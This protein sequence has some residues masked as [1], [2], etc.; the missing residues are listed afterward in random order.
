MKTFKLLST[1]TN[2]IGNLTNRNLF[3]NSNNNRNLSKGNITYEY[4]QDIEHIKS[5]LESI[6]FQNNV[7]SSNPA[8]KK[9]IDKLEKYLTRIIKFF[10]ELNTFNQKTFK[11]LIESKLIPILTDTINILYIN[12]ISNK[13]MPYLHKLIFIDNKI[14]AKGKLKEESTIINTQLVGC[15]KKIITEFKNILNNVNIIN[16]NSDLDIFINNGILP[17]LNDLFCKLIKYP[18][19]YYALVNDSTTIN[20]NLELLLFEI[21]LNLLKFEHQIKN[22]TS[23]ALI[24]KNLLRFLNNFNLPNKKELMKKIINYLIYNLI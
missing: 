15:T 21:V 2:K 4:E 16:V 13:I 12:T 10:F 14:L 6:K 11:S 5:L 17:F 24:R 8:L 9:S 7:D 19:F 3:N 22:R 1:I 20:I 18:N 23:R